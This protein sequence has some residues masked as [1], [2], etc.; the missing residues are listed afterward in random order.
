M[1]NGMDH[2]WGM[3]YGYGWIIGLVLFIIAV[4]LVTKIMNQKK[5]KLR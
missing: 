2:T 5:T 3:G 4:W 1:I